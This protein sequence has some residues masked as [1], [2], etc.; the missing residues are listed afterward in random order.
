MSKN[1]KVGDETVTTA[2]VDVVNGEV[3]KLVAQ[4]LGRVLGEM[5]QDPKLE[6]GAATGNLLAVAMDLKLRLDQYR[7]YPFL[8]CRMCRRWFPLT[9]LR[10][11]K[12]FLGLLPGKLDTGLSLPFQEFALTHGN[13]MECIHWL[14]SPPAQD[15][16][17]HF[18][19]AIFLHSLNAERKHAAVKR[20]LQRKLCHLATVSTNLI[21]THYTRWRTEQR[22]F[23]NKR[24]RNC[25]KRGASTARILR[26]CT[27]HR[28]GRRARGSG[29][30]RQPRAAK[31]R[32]PRAA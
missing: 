26:G 1:P 27:M 16:L 10:A 9:F 15:F 22:A 20:W 12:D 19:L 18:V 31:P 8:L 29:Q 24:R 14:S 4:R 6:H 3:H 21:C 5:H 7:L 17:E 2:V 11:C 23:S 28:R 32:Q 25:A 13:S 30:P